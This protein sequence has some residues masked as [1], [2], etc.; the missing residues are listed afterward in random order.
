MKKFLVL[1]AICA[2]FN[3]CSYDDCCPDNQVVVEDTN[4]EAPAD[5]AVTLRVKQALLVDDSLSATARFISVSTTDGVVT[6]EG[7]VAS[8]SEGRY[9]IKSV[10]NVEGVRRVK[11][12]LRVSR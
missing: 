8:R 11:N 12:K 3:S 4:G 5:W 9:V 2:L 7:T 6:L 1:F 10:K